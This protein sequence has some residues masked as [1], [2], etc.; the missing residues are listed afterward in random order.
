MTSM[1]AQTLFRDP[2]GPMNSLQ[3]TYDL[4]GQ[5]NTEINQQELERQARQER[6][7]VNMSIEIKRATWVRRG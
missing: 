3:R 1:D 7:R 2:L 4:G 5:E 6:H